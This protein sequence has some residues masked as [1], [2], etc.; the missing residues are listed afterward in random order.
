MHLGGE[1]KV[2]ELLRNRDTGTSPIDTGTT[3]MSNM[4]IWT[5]AQSPVK[6]TANI[7]WSPYLVP[8]PHGPL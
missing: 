4:D 1:D 3:V 8:F 7:T 6:G 2:L 5:P